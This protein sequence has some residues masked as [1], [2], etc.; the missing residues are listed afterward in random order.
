[1]RQGE[2]ATVAQCGIVAAY[3]SAKSKEEIQMFLCIVGTASIIG[4][5]YVLADFYICFRELRNLDG[6][7]D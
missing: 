1:M 2:A 4:A 5:I 7:N 3:H 6:W